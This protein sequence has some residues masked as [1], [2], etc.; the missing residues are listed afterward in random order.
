M[1]GLAS[2]F[3]PDQKETRNIKEMISSISHRGPDYEG[4]LYDE[5]II[6]GS[7]RLSIFDLSSRGNMPMKDKSGRYSI[8]YNGEIYNFKELKEKYKIST[9]SGSDTEVLIELFAKI[10]EK[11]FNEI[12]GIYAFVIF[13]K[14][15]SKVYC[16]RDRLGVKPLYYYKSN[17]NYFF[18]SE[19]KG[20]LKIFNEISINEKIVKFYLQ[21]T[22]YDF[23]E[24]TFFQGIYQVAQGTYHIYDLK[25]KDI[26]KIKYW[27][28]NGNKDCQKDFNLIKK[29][30]F[31]SFS[32]QQK[33]DTKIG[34]NVSSGIDSNLMIS[35]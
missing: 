14:N 34:L 32:L 35:F 15:K 13:D 22:Y 20:I 23:S 3:G 10:G 29:H 5:N 21:S 33:S 12:N 31:D 16:V 7:C 9:Y 1:C 28:L 17:N 8:I 24:A 30:F 4:F 11:I 27:D 19:I 18:S 26:K 6:M 25:N 2:I